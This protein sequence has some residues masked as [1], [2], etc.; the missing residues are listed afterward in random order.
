MKIFA[1]ILLALMLSLAAVAQSQD[2]SGSQGQSGSQ[3][4]QGTQSQGT[5]TGSQTSSQSN[6][7]QNMSGTVSKNGRSFTNDSNS[8]RYRVDNPDALSGKEG[9]HVALLV[10]VD[11]DNGVIHVIQLEPQQ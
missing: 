5:Q 1:S 8:R 7:N 4:S 9:Q 2:Q 11:P 10:Q 6:S 3:A